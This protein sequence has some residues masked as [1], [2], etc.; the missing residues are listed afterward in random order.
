MIER[1]AY[2]KKSFAS[3]AERVAFLFTNG[4]RLFL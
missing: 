1:F 2:G 3:D 4:T